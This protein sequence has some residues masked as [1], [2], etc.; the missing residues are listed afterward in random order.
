MTNND[1]IA[2]VWKAVHDNKFHP[3]V[4]GTVADVHQMSAAGVEYIL[5]NSLLRRSLDNVTTVVVAFSNFKHTVFGHG[6]TESKDREV[7][8]R[9]KSIQKFD[10]KQGV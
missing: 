1:T 6:R 3:S 2:C 9:T 10:P 5:K 7:L 8:E 4:K